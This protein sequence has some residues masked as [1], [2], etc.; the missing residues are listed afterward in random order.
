[1]S[2]FGACALLLAGIG[3]YGL[4]AYSVQQRT[5]EIGIRM[6]LGADVPHVRRMVFR[7]GLAVTSIG[8]ALGLVGSFALARS[9]SALLFHVSPNDALV[10]LTVPLILSATALLGIV[11]PCR[12]A[13]RVTPIEALRVE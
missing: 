9:V 5:R 3:I 13:T 1:M 11:I 4:M 12:R 6:A 10:F 8:I 7:D 2:M